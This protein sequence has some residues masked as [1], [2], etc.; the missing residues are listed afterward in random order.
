MS[1]SANCVSVKNSTLISG[2]CEFDVMLTA[3]FLKDLVF[4]KVDV[5]VLGDTVDFLWNK[6]TLLFRHSY[7]LVKKTKI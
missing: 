6:S 5:K 7:S 4:S 1:D 2:S 3:C